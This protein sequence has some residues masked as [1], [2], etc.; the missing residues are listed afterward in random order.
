[1]AIPDFDIERLKVTL[2]YKKPGRA[3]SLPP[4]DPRKSL[5]LHGYTRV[6]GEDRHGFASGDTT[7]DSADIEVNCYWKVDGQCV[8][9]SIVASYTYNVT[10]HSGGVDS[11]ASEDISYY[12]DGVEQK[13]TLDPMCHF[14]LNLATTE[15][16]A[17]RYGIT[18]L[19]CLKEAMQEAIDRLSLDWSINDPEDEE[20]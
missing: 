5:V 1:M 18:I 3:I 7:D 10:A 15:T 20:K 2:I 9:T 6:S 16:N 19:D 4:T 11:I 13:C 17:S 14:T 12:V 8:V